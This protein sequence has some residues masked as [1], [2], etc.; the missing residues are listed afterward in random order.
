MN[1]KPSK[2]AKSILISV[3]NGPVR[4][5]K[6]NRPQK[7]NAYNQEM[8]TELERSI[9]E[10]EMDNKSKILVITGSGNRAFCAGSDLKEIQM[11][12]YKSALDLKS[13]HIFKAIAKSTKITIAAINGAA[14]GG[15]LELALSCDLRVC[16][17]NAT[18]ALPET[19][20]GYIP[21]AGGTQRLTGLVGKGRAKAIILGGESWDAVEALNAGLVNKIVPNDKLEMAAQSWAEKI[22]SRNTL[23]LRLAKQ[24]IDLNDNDSA[25]HLIEKLSEALLYELNNKDK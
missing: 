10:F 14:Y 2:S 17:S 20:L 7:A 9:N 3:K 1:K 5:I 11:K 12:N 21:A 8:L 13:A 6:L 15:G 25:G 19:E 23:A 18:F 4:W 22:A 24:A 16:S